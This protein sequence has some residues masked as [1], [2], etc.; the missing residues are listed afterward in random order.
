MSGHIGTLIIDMNGS[1]EELDA[2][3]DE[4]GA[5]IRRAPQWSPLVKSLKPRLKITFELEFDPMPLIGPAIDAVVKLFPP[6]SEAKG[7]AVGASG[8][9]VKP[10]PGMYLVG[11]RGPEFLTPAKDR[12]E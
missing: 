6:G 10:Q 3:A 9:F 1:A 4:F 7:G 11:E 8:G 5:M 2:A 12:T